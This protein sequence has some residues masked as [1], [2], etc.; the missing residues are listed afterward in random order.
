MASFKTQ[1]QDLINTHSRENDSDTPNFLLAEYL[2]NC[3]E[4][5]ELIVNKRDSF[6]GLPHDLYKKEV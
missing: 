1:L 6:L 3:L 2:I 5:Y 4:N